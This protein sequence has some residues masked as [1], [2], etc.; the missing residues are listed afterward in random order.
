MSQDCIGDTAGIWT[1]FHTTYYGSDYP[2]FLHQLGGSSYGNYA[3]AWTYR[4]K[5]NWP[6]A[7]RV[8]IKA[9]NPPQVYEVVA[10]V[11]Q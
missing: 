5:D 6:K 2:E 11:P 3:A 1:A 10:D 9:G 8:R 7:I 4:H